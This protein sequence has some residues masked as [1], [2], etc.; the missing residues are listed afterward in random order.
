[1]R[2]LGSK[3]LSQVE[4]LKTAPNESLAL[5][6]P[7]MAAEALDRELNAHSS[8]TTA[9]ASAPVVHNLTSTIKRKK[10]APEN[11]SKR[12]AEDEA[13]HSNT[14]KKVRLDT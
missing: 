9:S 13:E 12:K 1:V 7:A 5:S 4:E 14:D 8:A 11:P 2:F 6:A 3:I 10:K